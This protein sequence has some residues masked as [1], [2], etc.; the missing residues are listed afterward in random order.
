MLGSRILL[1]ED[2]AAARFG[3][4]SFLEAH[5]YE[6]FS[7]ESC[8]E[9]LDLFKTSRPD[10][11]MHD[12]M[13]P[14]GNALD[15]LPRLK[16]VDSGTPIIILTGLGTIDLAVRAIKEGAE[17]FLTKPLELSSLLSILQ[18]LIKSHRSL[19]IGHVPQKNRIIPTPCG[20]SAP[21]R[22][23]GYARHSHPASG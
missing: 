4:T 7:A 21:I 19:W 22:T 16:E 12:Y 14:D 1:V 6:V 17:Q 11:V 18:R 23:K 15:F 13:L 3:I 2:D 8:Q 10:V 20:E 9:G 5:D